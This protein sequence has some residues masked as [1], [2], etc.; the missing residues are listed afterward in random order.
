[1]NDEINVS[2]SNNQVRSV[3]VPSRAVNPM[4][5]PVAKMLGM[6]VLLTGLLVPTTGRAAEEKRQIRISLAQL[7]VVAETMEKGAFVDLAKALASKH[8][9]FDFKYGIYPFVRSLENVATKKADLHLPFI[10]SENGSKMLASMGLEYAFEPTNRVVF[11]LYYKRGNTKLEG[12][13]KAGFPLAQQDNFKIETDAGHVVF[14][15]DHKLTANTCMLCMLRKVEQG[16][17]D[18]MVFAAKEI[19]GL[20][21]KNKIVGIDSVMFKNFTSSPVFRNTPEG[22][23][24]NR[25]FSVLIRQMKQS[26]EIAKVMAPYNLFYETRFP[27]VPMLAPL[28]GPSSA[29]LK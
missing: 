8:P 22:K 29:H 17:V 23:V 2:G 14:F 6:T 28:A 4:V 1:M 9:E 12:W 26:G 20:I 25:D 27:G 15:D 13:A 18:G 10:N 7:P 5:L 24:L 11:A 16:K 21:E 19:D 3:C